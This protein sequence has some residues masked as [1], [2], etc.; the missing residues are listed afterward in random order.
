MKVVFGERLIDARLMGAK[1][2]IALQQQGDAVE[3]R[4]ARRR[5]LNLAGR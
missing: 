2:T 3:G 4:S 5:S 1:R